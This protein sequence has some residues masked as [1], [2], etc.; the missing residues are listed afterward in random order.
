VV[1][2]PSVFS[3]P[4]PA[5]EATACGAMQVCADAE[6]LADTLVALFSDAT[7]LAAFRTRTK[8]LTAHHLGAAVRSADAL[9]PLGV[10]RG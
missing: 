1:T 2:G 4:S 3:I 9:I 10:H 8:G 6:A 5:D 7:A